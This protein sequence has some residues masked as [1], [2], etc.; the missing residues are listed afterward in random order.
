MLVRCYR[1][2]AVLMGEDAANIRSWMQ[3]PNQHLG[4]VPAELVGRVDGLVNT[5]LYLDAI[6]GR[7]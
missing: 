1:S 5:C 4:G 6:R 2:L 3:S 7:A